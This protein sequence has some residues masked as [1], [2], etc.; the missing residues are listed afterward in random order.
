MG[1]VWSSALGADYQLEKFTKAN[2]SSETTL[3][4]LIFDPMLNNLPRRGA[5]STLAA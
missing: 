2:K 5:K 4:S 3:L 1:D